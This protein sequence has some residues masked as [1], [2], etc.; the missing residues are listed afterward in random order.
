MNKKRILALL[1][2][3]VMLVS[4]MA[5]LT[6]CGKGKSGDEKLIV[7]DWNCKIDMTDFMNQYLA[8]EDAEMGEYIKIN[9]FAVTLTWTFDD[10]GAVTVK[11]DEAAI[12]ETLDGVV[13]DMV[14]GMS[15]YLTSMA[16]ENGMTL[17]QLLQASGMSLDDLA[18]QLRD[19][20]LSEM[21]FSS[22]NET[23]KYEFKDG[24][25]YIDGEGVEYK[26]DGN[27]TL[28]FTGGEG[29]DSLTGA[30]AESGLEVDILPL[31]LTRI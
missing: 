16:E 10:K 28:N 4:C 1:L 9:D 15:A 12:T 14:D 27:D 19:S 3:L 6:A 13:D 18:N 5:A 30:M 23:G 8:Q 25:L 2:A 29:M 20:M 17:D 21:D 7:G 22:M 24:L 26:F 31:V 11:A